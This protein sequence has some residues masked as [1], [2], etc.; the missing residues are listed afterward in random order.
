MFHSRSTTRTTGSTAGNDED[1]R[2]MIAHSLPASPLLVSSETWGDT[3]LHTALSKSFSAGANY[4]TEYP[5][6]AND[7]IKYHF[8]FDFFAGV[9]QKGGLSVLLS[10][11]LPGAL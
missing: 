6:F 8:G 4:P 11:N 10:F 1:Q 3:A 2:L 5:F 7:P 9:L